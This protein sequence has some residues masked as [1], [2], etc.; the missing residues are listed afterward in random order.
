MTLSSIRNKVKG[1]TKLMLTQNIELSQN[2]MGS[3]AHYSQD[4]LTN[5]TWP[6]VWFSESGSQ[7]ELD[8]ITHLLEMSVYFR[9]TA[10]TTLYSGIVCMV[11]FN[12]SK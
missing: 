12:I 9:I 11:L 4:H 1:V 5:S 10:Y 2:L 8:E 3:F 6:G 7:G